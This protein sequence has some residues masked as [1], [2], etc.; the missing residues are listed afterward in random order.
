MI[1]VAAAL[2]LALAPPASGT[3]PSG[4][5]PPGPDRDA[6]RAAV[7][8]LPDDE[9]SGALVRVSG[10]RGSWRGSGGV[11]RL[12]TRQPVHP[13]GRF[14][15]GSITKLFTATA[16]LKLAGSGRLDLDRTVQHYLPGLLTPD[17]KPVTVRQLLDHTH[18]IAGHGLPHKD[19]DWFLAHRYDTFDPREVV[20]LGVA[21]GP[22]FDPGTRQ[23]YGNAGYLVAGLV[24][25][26]VTGRPYAETVREEVI[27]PL[28]LRDTHLP[29]ADPRIRGPHAHGYERTATG[30]V[31]VTETNPTLQWAAAEAVSSAPD[32][33]RFLGAL[34]RG[35]FLT[36]AQRAEL[37]TVPDAP[38][39]PGTNAPGTAHALGITRIELAP[40]LVVW[41]KSGD[42]PGYNNGVA[43]TAD[44]AR[45]LVYSV[46]TLRMGGDQPDAAVRIITAAFSPGPRR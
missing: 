5:T 28:G 37:L 13:D 23:E 4:T 19:P 25:E 32:L 31:D 26:A 20:E 15:V 30:H 27:R 41:G 39:V 21:R 40:G 42:R 14:R 34:L 2:A 11:A 29:G 12:G 8:P 9:A 16:A 1:P 10:H 46:N 7:A 3:T 35:D 36:P 18:G 44:G 17:F 33:D 24:I 38:A 6:L 43:G 22:R 45:T